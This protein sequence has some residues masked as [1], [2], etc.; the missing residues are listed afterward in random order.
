M[1]QVVL[2]LYAAA[3][4]LTKEMLYNGVTQR[5]RI[6]LSLSL[7][8]SLSPSE[9]SYD[10]DKTAC[11]CNVRYIITSERIELESPSCLAYEADQICF[12]T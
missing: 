12:T 2:G 5:I 7:S 11:I 9:D 10:K 3:F 1:I 4:F 8:L 6:S